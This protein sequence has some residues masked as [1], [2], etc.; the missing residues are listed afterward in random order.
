MIVTSMP[1]DPYKLYPQDYVLRATLLRL[2]PSAVTPNHI[3]VLRM[4]L[5]PVVLYL[6]A[7]GNLVFGVP[8][9]VFTAFTDMVDGSMARVRKHI[10]PWGILF[11]P[12]ADKLLIGLVA[13]TF[14]L[15]YYH[16]IIVI[17]AV[18]FDLIPLAIWLVRA[19][20]NRGVMMANTWGKM[21]MMLQFVSLTMLLLAVVLQLPFLA[22]VGEWTLV[23]ATVFAAVATITY[24]L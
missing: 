6:L 7:T 9:F 3:T 12:I 23:L 14:A 1:R 2:I 20:G 24:S 4:M 13:L 5:T 18:A 11:D 21:K 16:P 22:D 8:L 17:T 19:K 10:T 15:K